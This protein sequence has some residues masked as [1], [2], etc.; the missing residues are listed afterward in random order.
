MQKNVNGLKHLSLNKYQE[1]CLVVTG[2][3]VIQLNFRKCISEI[4]QIA[5][6]ITK[7]TY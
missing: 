3:F 1:M 2:I 5:Q 4:Y 7:H 6:K